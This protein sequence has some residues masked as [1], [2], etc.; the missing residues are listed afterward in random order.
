MNP[1]MTEKNHELLKATCELVGTEEFLKDL[2]ENPDYK[3]EKLVRT[4]A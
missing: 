2:I 3:E 4:E 1:H